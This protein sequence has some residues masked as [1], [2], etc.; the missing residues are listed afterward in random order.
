MKIDEMLPKGVRKVLKGKLRAKERVV[1]ALPAFSIFRSRGRW[2]WPLYFGLWH[3]PFLVTTNKHIILVAKGLIRSVFISW[4]F[5]DIIGA[6]LEPKRIGDRVTLTVGEWRTRLRF[7]K[8]LRRATKQ[9]VD[10]LWMLIGSKKK[11]KR[12]MAG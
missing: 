7:P 12:R 4:E 2:F 6:Q 8:K 9:L 3:P 5:T 10:Q 1:F 11:K